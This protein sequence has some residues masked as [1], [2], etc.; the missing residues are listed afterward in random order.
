MFRFSN[1]NIQEINIIKLKN[2]ITDIMLNVNPI[3]KQSNKLRFSIKFSSLTTCENTRIEEI[4]I[5]KN[6][7]LPPKLMNKFEI[8][9]I[10]L[11]S[12]VLFLLFLGKSF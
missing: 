8:L 5:P 9:L 10:C 3:L 6:N 2:V 7:I 1:P 11:A 12:F 4:H